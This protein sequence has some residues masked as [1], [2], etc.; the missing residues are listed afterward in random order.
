MIARLSKVL[1]VDV[2]MLL[3]A[4]VGSDESPNVI[5]VDDSKAIPP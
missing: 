4:A 1:E 2:N 5:L 3:S